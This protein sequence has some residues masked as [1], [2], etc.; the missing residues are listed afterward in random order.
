MEKNIIT[1][2]TYDR[3]FYKLQGKLIEQNGKSLSATSMMNQSDVIECN[4]IDTFTITL[5]KSW[6]KCKKEL[7]TKF[8]LITK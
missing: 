7:E 5:K 8:G 4:N 2:K 1:Y 3:F 6:S